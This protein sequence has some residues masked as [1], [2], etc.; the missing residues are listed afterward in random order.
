MK[1]AFK[2]LNILLFSILLFSCENGNV[3]KLRREVGKLNAICPI[4]AGVAGD[5]LSIKYNEKEGI[6]YMYFASNEEYGSQFFLKESR[7]NLRTNLK[8]M[9][10][11]DNYYQFLKDMVNAQASLILTYKIPSTGQSTSFKIPYEELKEIKNNPISPRER[12]RIILENQ[13]SIENARC[14]YEIEEGLKMIKNELVDDNI[15]FYIQVDEDIYNFKEWENSSNEIK[16]FTSQNFKDLKRDPTMQNHLKL[17]T[18]AGIGYHYR[19]FGS[20]TKKYVDVIF[21]PQELANYL[22]K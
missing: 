12:D 1:S 18:S 2:I 22:P 14:P 17:L 15:V 3:T 19:Y 21:T 16:D 10:Q 4:S 5:F 11:K 20:K 13:I 9:F 8:L 6:V 7:E